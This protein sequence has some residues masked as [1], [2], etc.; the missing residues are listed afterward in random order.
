MESG[1]MKKLIREFSISWNKFWLTLV[2]YIFTSLSGLLCVPEYDSFAFQIILLCSR[3]LDFVFQDFFTSQAA[4]F[5]Q[6]TRQCWF[7]AFQVDVAIT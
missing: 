1:N 6:F 3:V 7:F 4:V 2:A 5:F